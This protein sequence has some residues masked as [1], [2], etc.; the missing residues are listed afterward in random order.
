MS[1]L[2]SNTVESP[3]PLSELIADEV[4][5]LLDSE[6]LINQKSLR[7]YQIR[8]KFKEMRAENIGAN[9]AI[10]AIRD[11]YPYLQFDTLRKIVY[12]IK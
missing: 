5:F 2:S 12:D 10:N 3:N 11:E 7:N 8:K 4:Y 9:I 6:G 1:L